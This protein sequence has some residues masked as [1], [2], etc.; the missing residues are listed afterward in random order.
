VAIEDIQDKKKQLADLASV[1]N[2]FKS[3]AVQ[4]RL[5]E[6]LL[7]ET[8]I[9]G[10]QHSQSDSS[11]PSSHRGRKQR[12]T[13]AGKSDSSSPEK[14]S[15]QRQVPELLLRLGNWLMETSSRNR[16]PS[17]TLLSTANTI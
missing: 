4:L 11:K 5:L 7:G 8:G 10:E 16:A 13:S 6:H 9:R 15:H 3:E 14:R 1:L 2:S 17:V 12:K